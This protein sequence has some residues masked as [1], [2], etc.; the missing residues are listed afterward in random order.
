MQALR[1]GG[2]RQSA[3]YARMAQNPGD[4]HRGVR[5]PFFGGNPADDGVEFR[6]LVV[7]EINAFKKAILERGPGLDR[8]VMKPAVFKYAAVMVEGGAVFHIDMDTSVDH[9]G[10]HRAELQLI[11]PAADGAALF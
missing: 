8:H 10:V 4:D 2:T 1:V 11:G 6:E 3:A 7:I 9:A 5:H